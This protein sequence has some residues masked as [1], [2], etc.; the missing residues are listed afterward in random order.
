Q[1]SRD[2]HDEKGGGEE[3]RPPRVDAESHA[4]RPSGGRLRADLPQD[5]RG[6]VGRRRL[7]RRGSVRGERPLVFVDRAAAGGAGLEMG[8]ELAPLLR[9]ELPVVKTREEIG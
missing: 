1:G 3:T 8:V 4:E 5:A 9:V 7:R 2:Q 6:E